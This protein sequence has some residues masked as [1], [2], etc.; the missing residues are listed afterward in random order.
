M[1][2]PRGPKCKSQKRT[3]GWRTQRNTTPANS[4]CVYPVTACLLSAHKKICFGAGNGL[5]QPRKSGVITQPVY[6][7]TRPILAW[8]GPAEPRQLW[9]GLLPSASAEMS[10]TLELETGEGALGEQSVDQDLP[11]SGRSSD[12]IDSPAMRFWQAFPFVVS[13]RSRTYQKQHQNR[14]FLTPTLTG[15][16]PPGV[17]SAANGT[18]RPAVCSPALGRRGCQL[19][20]Q[21]LVSFEEL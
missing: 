2:R 14:P 10:T 20:A 17:Q 8:A 7:G 21:F 6:L 11:V 15:N 5:F 9:K 13:G 1:G 19:R 4:S 12:I 18:R 3:S 16:F